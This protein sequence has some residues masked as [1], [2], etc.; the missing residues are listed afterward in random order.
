MIHLGCHSRH[1]ERKL[2][3][4]QQ[5]YVISHKR[6]LKKKKKVWIEFH[7]IQN[8]SW[9]CFSL[10]LCCSLRFDPDAKSLQQSNLT[11]YCDC[12]YVKRLFPAVFTFSLSATARLQHG[13]PVP[14]ERYKDWTPLERQAAIMFCEVKKIGRFWGP[15]WCHSLPSAKHYSSVSSPLLSLLCES[16]ATDC[17]QGHHRL[18]A[19][20]VNDSDKVKKNKIMFISI[21]GLIRDL[22]LW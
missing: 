22:Q 14:E 20:L 7:N 2:I 17:S 15:G 12:I 13:F 5:H 4:S 21:M 11:S 18:T 3:S 16:V 9:W 19:G 6:C 10:F 1:A 8:K